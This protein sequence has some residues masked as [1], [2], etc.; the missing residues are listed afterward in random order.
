LIE[1]KKKERER[2][3]RSIVPIDEHLDGSCWC[4]TLSVIIAVVKNVLS[5]TLLVSVTEQTAQYQEAVS[6]CSEVLNLLNNC[7]S[8]NTTLVSTLVDWII[9]SPTSILLQPLLTAA[10]RTLASHNHLA[11]VIE[12]CIDA[13]FSSGK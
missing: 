5:F 8:K 11:L 9:S 10:C 13:H 3:R 2:K 6:Q 12:A 7:D 1:E 4:I